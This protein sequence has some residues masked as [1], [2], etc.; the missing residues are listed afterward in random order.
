[1]VG[2]G[3]G[4]DSDCHSIY[5]GLELARG[6]E[7]PLDLL[8]I[9]IAG[10]GLTVTQDDLDGAQTLPSGVIFGIV[11]DVPNALDGVAA[12]IQQDGVAGI[13]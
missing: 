10:R 12:D 8:G 5:H 3:T 9:G 11:D 6:V 1:M 2:A 7:I 13:E 4:G